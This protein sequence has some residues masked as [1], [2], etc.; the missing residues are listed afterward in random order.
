MTKRPIIGVTMGDPCGN[1]PEITIKALSDP[2]L[3][4]KCRPIVIGDAACMQYA[5]ETAERI[6][7]VKKGTLAVHLVHSVDEALF[8]FG[9]IDVYDLGIV[10]D[11]SDRKFGIACPLGGEAAF[12]YV[13]KVIE[14]AMEGQVDATVTNALSKEA[15]NMAGHHF[16]GHTEIYAHFTGTEK[17]TMML[18]H[19]N[20]RVV[21]VSTHVSLRE[22]CDRV[23]KDRVLDC[24]RIAND[25]CRSLGI[26]SPKVAVAGLNPHCGED[27]LFGREEIDEIQPAINAALAEG[28]CI[29]D[30]KPTP[31]DTVF[32]KAI[33]GWY[34]NRMFDVWMMMLFGVVAYVLEQLG[35][36]MTPIIL[37]FILGPMIEKY[38]RS[39]MIASSGMFLDVFTRP[40]SCVFM[41]VAVT[42][43]LLPLFKMLRCRQKARKG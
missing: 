41:I 30:G 42:F 6:G 26:Q 31:A 29:P 39:A 37:G 13:K 2:E 40:I 15:I 24:I 33:G 4:R 28:I 22:A 5:L 19:E 36:D 18:A 21:H 32:S 9:S 7:V 20:L 14:L 23:K 12:Q 34:D 16:S 27:G 38:F 25:G 1:G 43:L 8:T 35:V 11:I 10:T 17:Y 3:Y